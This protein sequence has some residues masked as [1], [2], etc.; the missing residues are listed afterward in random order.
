MLAKWWGQLFT[1]EGMS[2]AAQRIAD[3]SSVSRDCLRQWP[4][5]PAP[6]LG[7]IDGEQL[8]GAFRRATKRAT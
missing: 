5:D 4:E 8:R 2:S 3:Y 7:P 6:V 1:Q